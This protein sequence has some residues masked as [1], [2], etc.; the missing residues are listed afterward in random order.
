M[1]HGL[2]NTSLQINKIQQLVSFSCWQTFSSMVFPQFYISVHDRPWVWIIIEAYQFSL[3]SYKLHESPKIQMKWTMLWEVFSKRNKILISWN[4]RYSLI[5]YTNSFIF[6]KLNFLS[7]WNCPQGLYISR[8]S[9]VSQSIIY[10][11]S[12]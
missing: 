2:K 4:Y 1:G 7:M 11:S 12:H 3:L 8:S 10:L 9:S 6:L 5:N